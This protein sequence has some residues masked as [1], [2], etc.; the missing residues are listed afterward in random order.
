MVELRIIRIRQLGSSMWPTIARLMALHLGS[1][2]AF[3]INSYV[4]Y[5]VA[6]SHF[7]CGKRYSRDSVPEIKCSETWRLCCVCVVWQKEN[8]Y[9]TS[10]F[11]SW[12]TQ[13]NRAPKKYIRFVMS[14]I[15]YIFI[16]LFY[17][18]TLTLR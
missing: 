1:L 16:L 5:S 8:Y 14:N 12:F 10:Y 9:S 4:A 15:P 2:S 18:L 6:Q 3:P 17:A 13:N 11:K 7:Q